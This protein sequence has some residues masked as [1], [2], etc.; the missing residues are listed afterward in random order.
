MRKFR[1]DL[2]LLIIMGGCFYLP[3]FFVLA[4]AFWGADAW[5]SLWQFIRS[6]VFRNTLLFSLSEALLSAAF[7]LVIAL[8]GAY[9]FG[10]Y[11]FPGKRLLRSWLAIPFMLPGILVVLGLVIFYG[12]NGVFSQW[13]A[14]LFPEAHW[15][16]NYLYSFWGIVLAN[17]FYNFAFCLRLLGE[18]WEKIDPRLSEASQLH[19]A[20]ALETWLRVVW[21]L[22]RPTA[23]YLFTMV[24]LY[25][26][27]SFTVVLILGGYLYKTFEVLIYIE[28]NSKLNLSGAATIAALQMLLLA[29]VLLIQGMLARS[30]AAYSN[31]Q[32]ERPA[33]SFRRQPLAT[34]LFLTYLAT[35]TLFFMSPLIAVIARSF[36]T[37]SGSAFTFINYASLMGT[38]FTFAIGKSFAQVLGSSLSIAFIAAFS[39]VAFAYLV[40]WFRREEPWGW[41]DLLCQLPL[42]FSFLTFSTGLAGWVGRLLPGWILVIWA[43]IFL[44]FP[45]VY[46]V[47]R[48]ARRELSRSLT[49]ASAVLGAGELETFCRIEMPLMLKP[50]QTGF[51]YAA[52]ISLGDLSAVLVLGK[53]EVVTLPV[54]IYRLIGHYHFPAATALGTL[55]ILFSLLLY[56][57][58]QGQVRNP[59]GMG[60]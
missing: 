6:G 1:R 16:M 22:L 20:G 28:F 56:L 35:I 32:A 48:T 3:V 29:G 25:S 40:A 18:R 44:A 53:G 54:A 37:Q 49:E 2:I 27:L 14:G 38:G 26:F 23:A 59:S 33:L 46:S 4:Q 42:G 39:T 10:R 60:N 51:S 41:L 7:S 43:Q 5:A 8:P 45:L 21:P 13:L 17:V 58:I 11:D 36:Q 34:V 19:G 55:F 57:G 12:K 15:E 9:F 30:A 52:A 24:F 50:L 31:F 47:L